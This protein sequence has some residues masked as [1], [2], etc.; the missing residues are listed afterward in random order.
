[1]NT[2]KSIWIVWLMYGNKTMGSRSIESVHSVHVN[3]TNVKRVVEGKI[4]HHIIVKLYD[5]KFDTTTSMYSLQHRMQTINLLLMFENT[6]HKLVLLC[7]QTKGYYRIKK[8]YD[9]S[10]R[11]QIRRENKFLSILLSYFSLVC[12]WYHI[13]KKTEM[14]KVAIVCSDWDR[15][16]VHGHSKAHYLTDRHISGTGD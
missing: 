14:K 8:K 12:K 11:T 6:Q 10:K 4:F 13:I 16:T 5:I 7:E 3:R 15:L 2:N 1:M 9:G